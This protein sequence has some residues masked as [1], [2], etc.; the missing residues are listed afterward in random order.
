MLKDI[1]TA[2]KETYLEVTDTCDISELH[3]DEDKVACI[4][5]TFRN[6]ADKKIEAVFHSYLGQKEDESPGITTIQKIKKPEMV[7]FL[8]IG[9]EELR[10]GC[11]IEIFEEIMSTGAVQNYE[12]D[13]KTAEQLVK[14]GYLQKRYGSHQAVL[15]MIDIEKR[16]LCESLYSFCFSDESKLHIKNLEG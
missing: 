7:S 14:L 12:V 10:T 16:E 3:S 5:S 11:V 15:Y 4:S 6:Q 9:N 1:Q 8:R 13:T 2:L